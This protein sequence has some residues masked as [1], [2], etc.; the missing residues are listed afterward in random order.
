M[1]AQLSFYREGI[2][3]LPDKWQKAING[4]EQLLALVTSVFKIKIRILSQKYREL[5][6]TSNTNSQNSI[7]FTA[8][9]GKRTKSWP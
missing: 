6:S 8:A 7:I 1:T 2:R 9:P 3:K 5:I 4:D